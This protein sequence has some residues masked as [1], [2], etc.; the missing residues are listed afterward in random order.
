MI[1]PTHRPALSLPLWLRLAAPL[2]WRTDA[3][4]ASKLLGFA[5]TEEGSARDMQRASQLVETPRLRR[6]FYRHALDEARHARMFRAA[7]APYQEAAGPGLRS[8]EALHATR[9]DLLERYGLVKFV[10]FVWLSESR[11]ARQFDVLAAR[12]AD[13]DELRRLFEEIGK[14]EQFHTTYSRQ[15]LDEWCAGGREREVAQAL[16]SVR[17]SQAWMA[18]RRAG[19]RIGDVMTRALLIGMWALVVPPFALVQRLS[20]RGDVGWQEPAQSQQRLEDLR[21]QF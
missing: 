10:A 19:R 7:A 14:D 2:A 6:L 12:F 21:R 18:W 3:A 1:T 20:E 8:Y 4:I 16:R 13:R 9:Q 11:A 15:L 17:L 5:A